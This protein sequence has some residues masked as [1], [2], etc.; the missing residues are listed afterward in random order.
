MR[1]S[2]LRG[3]PV[4]SIRDAEKIGDVEDVLVSPS[5]RR[6]V[7]VLLVPFTP[8]SARAIPVE[9]VH[10]IGRDVLTIRRDSVVGTLNAGSKTPDVDQLTAN[11]LAVPLARLIGARALTYGG[12]ILGTVFDVEFDPSEF[13]ITTYEVA[14]SPLF[15]ILGRQKRVPAAQEVRF[16]KTILMFSEEM[17]SEETRILPLVRRMVPWMESKHADPEQAA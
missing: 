15:L 11:G 3:M 8:D 10:R 4:V 14:D 17:I 16:G 1:A 7:A 6:I 9:E 2:K 12:S 5:G 13:E